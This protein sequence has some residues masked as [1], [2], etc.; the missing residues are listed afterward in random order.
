MEGEYNG[1]FYRGTFHNMGSDLYGVDNRGE[2]DG[3]DERPG[4]LGLFNRLG[5]IAKR[6]GLDSKY[7][8]HENKWL[9]ARILNWRVSW[10]NILE[11]SN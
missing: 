9:N 7:W 1:Q 4:F 2:E 10:V 8:E 5:E 3:R 11:S 6:A